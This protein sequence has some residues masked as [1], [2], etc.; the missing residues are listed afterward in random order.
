MVND[1]KAQDVI[2]LKNNKDHIQAKVIEI[3]TGEIKYK[4]WAEKEDGLTYVIEKTAVT[5]VEFQNGRKEFFGVETMDIEEYFDGQ[6][7]GQ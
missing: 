6:K 1:L 5:R 4:L 7:N 3:G 2:H